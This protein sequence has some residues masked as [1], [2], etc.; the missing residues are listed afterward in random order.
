[1]NGLGWWKWKITADKNR[2]CYLYF[3]LI[4]AQLGLIYI[5]I[6]VI[7]SKENK[8]Y[9]LF[10]THACN[11]CMNRMASV[12]LPDNVFQLFFTLLHRINISCWWC[13]MMCK[14]IRCWNI[15]NSRL[16]CFWFCT[17]S[18][19]MQLQKKKPTHTP[20]GK[21]KKALRFGKKW[22]LFTRNHWL[23]LFHLKLFICRF[24]KKRWDSRRRM[25]G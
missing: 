25:L 12:S 8:T 3:E 11:E 4:C 19:S 22:L 5:Y 6:L 13:L 23:K 15:R 17:C 21:K 2:Y 14:A 1:M 24:K 7:V 10:C 9:F 20:K 18:K 16:F